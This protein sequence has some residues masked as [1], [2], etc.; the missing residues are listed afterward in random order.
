MPRQPRSQVD[1]FEREIA[2]AFDPGDFI[3][4][5]EKTLN[6]GSWFASCSAQRSEMGY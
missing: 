2:L 5:G 1:L 3:P 6:D 4:N